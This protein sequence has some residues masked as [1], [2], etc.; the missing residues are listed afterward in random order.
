[1]LCEL[2]ASVGYNNLLG[3]IFDL[4]LLFLGSAKPSD[5]MTKKNLICAS[6]ILHFGDFITLYIYHRRINSCTRDRPFNRRVG[7]EP[8]HVLD[9]E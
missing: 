4:H 2:C 9:L 1:M 3:G 8:G 6:M 5:L 7:I